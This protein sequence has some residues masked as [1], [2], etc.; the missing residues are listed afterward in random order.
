MLHAPEVPLVA[1]GNPVVR[2]PEEY[3]SSL[4]RVTQAVD[5]QI[6]IVAERRRGA[7]A[8]GLFSITY[9]LVLLTASRK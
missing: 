7:V 9:S 4:W 8:F 2:G 6:L 3:L 5:S 1:S